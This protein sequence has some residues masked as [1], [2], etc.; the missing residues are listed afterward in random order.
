MSEAAGTNASSLGGVT[1]GRLPRGSSPAG[2]AGDTVIG[3]P[4]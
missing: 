4:G 3:P 2:T 1:A